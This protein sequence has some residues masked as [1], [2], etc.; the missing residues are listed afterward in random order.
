M[1]NNKVVFIHGVMECVLDGDGIKNL[2]SLARVGPL[3]ESQ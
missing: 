1:M 3:S 2:E